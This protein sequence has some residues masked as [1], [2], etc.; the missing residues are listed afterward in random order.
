MTLRTY[1]E[2]DFERSGINDEIERLQAHL[3]DLDDECREREDGL[4][5]SAC[6]EEG[7]VDCPICHGENQTQPCS[8]CGIDG[9]VLCDNCYGT[10]RVDW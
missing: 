1:E 5:C 9:V 10:G 2:I 4:P 6:N 3:L 8:N 7:V